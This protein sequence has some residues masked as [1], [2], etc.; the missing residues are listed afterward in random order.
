MQ[1]KGTIQDEPPLDEGCL[2]GSNDLSGINWTMEKN[3][4]RKF[5]YEGQ[6]LIF[7]ISSVDLCIHSLRF[8]L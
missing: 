1:G 8:D 2:G 4:S 6:L 3:H 7:F 5:Q